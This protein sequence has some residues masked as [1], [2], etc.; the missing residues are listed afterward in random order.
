M[1]GEVFSDNILRQLPEDVFTKVQDDVLPLRG[2]LPL[3]DD[4]DAFVLD[5]ILRDEESLD[6]DKEDEILEEESTTDKLVLLSDDHFLEEVPVNIAFA[7]I[8]SEKPMFQSLLLGF[9][10]N[11]KKEKL[12]EKMKQEGVE[13]LR[14]IKKTSI[15]ESVEVK[16]KMEFIEKMKDLIKQEDKG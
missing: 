8:K 11:D 3:P 1:L 2:Q 10:H 15:L 4:I 13:V 6:F 12:I 14:S 9:F 16:L 5:N 7:V